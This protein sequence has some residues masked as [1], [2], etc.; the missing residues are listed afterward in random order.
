MS[1][2]AT[3]I[4]GFLLL[5]F[6]GAWS[7]WALAWLLDVFNTSVAG[8][9]I[10]AAGA[11]SPA[12]ASIVVR[13]LSGEGFADA[14]LRPNLRNRTMYYAVA[15]LL[16][17]PVLGVVIAL[18]AALGLPFANRDLPPTAVITALLAAVLA[19]P[20]FFGEELGWRGYLQIRLFAGRRPLLAA[21]F[22]GLVWGAF[23]FPVILAGFEGYEN[24]A[25]GLV[26]FPVF[27]VLLSVIFGWLRE[28]AGSTWVTCLAHSASNFVGGSLSAYLFLGSG[29]FI[30]TSFAGVL[31]W[32]PLGA[33]CAWIVLTGRLTTV[34]PRG[35]SSRGRLTSGL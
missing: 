9:L 15:W 31:T 13:W 1:R 28:R 30:L 11:F 8:Q 7:I 12:I 10:V 32:I 4:A 27:T 5:A 2:D 21:I 16:P 29:S 34:V 24:V 6:G 18:A 33:I 25:L 35:P 14:G 26:T 17:L 20:L 23:H 22:T 19:T 3:R